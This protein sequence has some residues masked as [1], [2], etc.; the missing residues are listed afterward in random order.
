MEK[1]VRLSVVGEPWEHPKGLGPHDIIYIFFL[2]KEM[3]F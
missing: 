3:S 2:K 1:E